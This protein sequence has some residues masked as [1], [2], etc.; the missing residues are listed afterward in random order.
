MEAVTHM[1]K[2][3]GI[4][5]DRTYTGKALAALIDDVKKQDLKD[6]VILFWNTCNLIDFLD[7]INTVDYHQLP[8]CFH[9]YFEEEVQP[10]DR[11]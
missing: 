5:L 4:K 8:Q 9:R 2:N 6:R 11:C 10:F 3:E 7:F 1:E